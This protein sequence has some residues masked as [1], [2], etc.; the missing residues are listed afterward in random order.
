MTAAEIVAEHRLARRLTQGDLA[1]FQRA[2]VSRSAIARCWATDSTAIGRERL[3]FDGMGRFEFERHCRGEALNGWTIMLFD[4]TGQ[5]L[6]L[7]GFR[8]GASGLWLGRAALIG[9]EQAFSPRI[10]SAG[11]PVLPDVWRWLANNRVGLVVLQPRRAF[12]TLQIAAP[13]EVMPDDE[14]AVRAF[15][16]AAM[17]KVIVRRPAA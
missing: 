13:L 6:D 10:S 17:P 2:G 12:S 3:V 1:H 16:K 8:P 9:A 11:I 4:E 15:L 7:Y 5:P 14:A